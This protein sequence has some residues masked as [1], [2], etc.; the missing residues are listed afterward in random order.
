MKKSNWTRLNEQS[1]RNKKI[2][3]L[4]VNKQATMQSIAD[5]FGI[6]KQRVAVIINRMKSAHNASLT[7]VE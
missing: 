4:R 5:E 3:D 1:E 2:F 7:V 6:S